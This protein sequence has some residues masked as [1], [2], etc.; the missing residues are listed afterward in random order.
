MRAYCS[1]SCQDSTFRAM[2]WKGNTLASSASVGLDD[3][4]SPPNVRSGGIRCLGGQRLAETVGNRL[5]QPGAE[6]S[7]SFAPQSCYRATQ[8]PPTLARN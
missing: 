5:P 1:E 6:A 4:D 2:I 8:S 7:R 3:G